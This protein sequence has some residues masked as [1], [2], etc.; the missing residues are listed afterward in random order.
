MLEAKETLA[1]LARQYAYLNTEDSGNNE[2]G[3]PYYIEFAMSIKRLKD[4]V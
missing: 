3:S 1:H 2:R 4:C